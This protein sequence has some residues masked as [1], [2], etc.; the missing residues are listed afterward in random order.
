M[1]TT[2]NLLALAALLLG[3]TACG[4][5]GL[6]DATKTP[7]PLTAGAYKVANLCAFE[8]PKGWTITNFPGQKYPMIAGPASDGFAPN[9]GVTDEKA[10][11]S[12]KRYVDASLEQLPKQIG[13]LTDLTTTEMNSAEGRPG[14]RLAYDA[15]QAG[16][17]LHLVQ[18]CFQGKNEM[19]IIVTFARKSTQDAGFDALFDASM[20]T[21]RLE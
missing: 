7:P 9:I 21:F 19:M 5:G 3:L 2:W 15:T 10:N 14:F 8:P 20:L 16:Q 4:G 17:K 1:K 18:Y 11:M 13:P 6:P 12:L